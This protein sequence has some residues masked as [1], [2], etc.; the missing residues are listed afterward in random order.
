LIRRKYL[1]SRKQGARI[2]FYSETRATTRTA[3]LSILLDLYRRS[4][5]NHAIINS[6][7]DYVVGQGWAVNAEGL[8]TLGLAKLQE[9]IDHPNQYESL[10]DILEKVALDYELIQR[11]RS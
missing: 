7:K 10:N 9:F 5:K 4:A 2:G 3:T 11:L 6:K 8:N 1:L